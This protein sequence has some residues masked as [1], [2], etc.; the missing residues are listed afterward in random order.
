MAKLYFHVKGRDV[1]LGT[2]CDIR[3]SVRKEFEKVGIAASKS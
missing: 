2:G 1:A 3:E